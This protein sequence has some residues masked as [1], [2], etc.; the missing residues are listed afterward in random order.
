MKYYPLEVL[1]KIEENPGDYLNLIKELEMCDNDATLQDLEDYVFGIDFFET[2][3][4][5]KFKDLNTTLLTDKEFNKLYMPMYKMKEVDKRKVEW[6]DML[7]VEQ[8]LNKWKQFKMVYKIDNDFFHEIKKTENIVTSYEMFKQLPFDCFFIDLTDV[9]NISDFKGAW[10]YI[11]HENKHNRNFVGVNIYMV[12]NE[13]PTFFSY[14]SWYNFTEE[15]EVTWNQEDLP[16]SDFVVRSIKITEN[17]TM[18]EYLNIEGEYTKIEF[19]HDPRKEII[20]TIF[21]I[22]AFIAI[23]ASDISENATTKRTY[24]PRR[25]GSVIKNKFSEVRMWD[26]GIRY[27]KAIHAAKQEY[28]KHLVQ[29]Q[30]A[31]NAQDAQENRKP[32]RPH[33]RRAH[34]HKYH[35]G[36]GRKETKVLWIAPV[37][38]CGNGKEIPVTI[39]EVKE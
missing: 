5:G 13:D 18:D 8:V 12:M 15:S 3:Y 39:R 28:K 26:V 35:V 29:E 21:Q 22:M 20:S 4:T 24:K 6:K 31:Q 7:G 14:Y 19:D 34:W 38:V 30:G 36:K 9:K 1:D 25:E 16:D 32:I 17:E 33:I 37:Y 27:G 2:M 10:V 23:D 11:K